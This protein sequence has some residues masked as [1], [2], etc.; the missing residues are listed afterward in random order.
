VRLHGLQILHDVR[1]D[2][3]SVKKKVSVGRDVYY[4]NSQR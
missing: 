3:L 1:F 4:V 2:F